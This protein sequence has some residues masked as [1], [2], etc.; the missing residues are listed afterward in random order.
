MVEVN[1]PRSAALAGSG[2]S[3]SYLSHAAGFWDYVSD[4]RVGRDELD[5]GFALGFV[6]NDIGLPDK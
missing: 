5:K 3:P 2:P 1:H 4:L 6:P